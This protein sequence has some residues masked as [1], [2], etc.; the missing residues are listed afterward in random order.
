MQA[1]N[2]VVTGSGVQGPVG[3]L[4]KWSVSSRRVEAEILRHLGEVDA[5]GLWADAAYS[6]LA[7]YC[8]EHLGYSEQMAY[9]R[10]RVARLSREIPAV[11]QAVAEGR[12]TVCGLCTVASLVTADNAGDWMAKIAGKTKREIEAL[13]ALARVEAGRPAPAPR[14]TLRALPTRPAPAGASAPPTP[15]LLLPPNSPRVGV[16][17]RVGDSLRGYQGEARAG[18][19][20]VASC[21][22]ER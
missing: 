21:S 20:V 15:T 5:Q 13:A 18:A 17:P 10:I 3:Q 6:S 2:S 8:M 9:K 12:A 1:M 19:G 4:E 22:A 16:S 14:N 11:L 7:A